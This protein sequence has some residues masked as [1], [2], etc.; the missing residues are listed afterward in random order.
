M[1]LDHNITTTERVAE[2]KLLDGAVEEVDKE[3]FERGPGKS[4]CVS[5]SAAIG[6]H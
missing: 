2:V 4:G 6:P 5:P 1:N 3:A